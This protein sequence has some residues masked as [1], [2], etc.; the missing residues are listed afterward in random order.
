[1]FVECFSA[2]KGRASAAEAPRKAPRPKIPE[3]AAR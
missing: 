3:S 1:M 2:L